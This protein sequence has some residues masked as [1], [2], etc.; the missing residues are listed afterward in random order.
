MLFGRGYRIKLKVYN[1]VAR[2]FG[3]PTWPYASGAVQARTPSETLNLQP[4]EWVQV[5][6]HEEILATLNG[7][8]NRGMGFSAEMVRYCGHVYR[9][10]SRVEKTIDEKTGHI[11]KLKNDCIILDDVVC[12]SECSTKRLFC[13]RSIFPYWRE[14]WLRRFT[15]QPPAP[16]AKR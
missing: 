8:K 3:E 16:E 1:R 4:G 14:I 10:R 2:L 7:Q 6:S 5:K 15:G 12:R 9:V 11:L 13:P